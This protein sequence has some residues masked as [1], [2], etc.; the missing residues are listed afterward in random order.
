MTL[1]AHFDPLARERCSG[2]HRRG[3][4]NDDGL[5]SS[6]EEGGARYDGAHRPIDTAMAATTFVGVSSRSQNS[7]SAPKE[8][9]SHA[10]GAFGPRLTK[11]FVK[12]P[13]RSSRARE[14]LRR[15]G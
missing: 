8:W 15:F 5:V 2:D 4:S 13:Q 3:R 14:A 1:H 9:R 11:T 10:R 12:S 7:A 6:S